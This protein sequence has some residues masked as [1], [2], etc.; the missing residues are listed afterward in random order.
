M[1][2]V[3]DASVRRGPIQQMP[4]DEPEAE[5]RAE[6]RE[7]EADQ[8]GADDWRHGHVLVDRGARCASAPGR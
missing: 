8:H 3:A 1:F 7:R 4:R 6:E 2:V 5:Q